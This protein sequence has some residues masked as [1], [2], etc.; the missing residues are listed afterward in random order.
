VIIISGLFF[1][2]N[3]IETN[4]YMGEYYM[5]DGFFVCKLVLQKDHTFSILFVQDNS[6][7]KTFDGTYTI[8]KDFIEL[9]P[10]QPESAKGICYA[11]RFVLIE[12]EKR[13]YLFLYGDDERSQLLRNQFCNNVSKKVELD[14]ETH[15]TFYMYIN[16]DDKEKMRDYS[17]GPE[18]AGFPTTH[19]GT[20]FCQEK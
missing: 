1:A 8:E 9:H 2:R 16:V 4:L 12:W 10:H 17:N 6:V 3:K 20:Y 11:K 7:S 18:D 14:R 13:R 5:G 15:G 19:D